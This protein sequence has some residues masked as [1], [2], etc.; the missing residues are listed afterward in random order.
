L[1]ELFVAA[2]SADSLA[3]ASATAVGTAT[4]F[5][6]VVVAAISVVRLVVRRVRLARAGGS[7]IRRGFRRVGAVDALALRILLVA[8]A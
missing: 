5:V 1:L 6:V 4:R 8:D 2:D 7:R 3:C